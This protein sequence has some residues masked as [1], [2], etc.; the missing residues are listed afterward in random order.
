MIIFQEPFTADSGPKQPSSLG[1]AGTPI[2]NHLGELFSIFEFLNPGFLGSKADSLG[3][4]GGMVP[5]GHGLNA[6]SIPCF[7]WSMFMSSRDDS[8]VLATKYLHGFTPCVAS[9]CVSGRVFE[10]LQPTA[11]KGRQRAAW[12]NW[13]IVAVP[14]CPLMGWSWGSNASR[15]PGD[16]AKVCKNGL[17]W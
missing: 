5:Q 2:E 9:F 16:A 14:W 7:Q 17:R 6:S 3:A 4:C 8:A 10:K 11:T 13:T 1:C 15:Q 12:S